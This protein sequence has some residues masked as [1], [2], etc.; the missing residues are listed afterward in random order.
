M[1]RLTITNLDLTLDLNSEETILRQLVRARLP[2]RHNCRGRARCTT[3]RLRVLEGGVNLG[4]KNRFE[5]FVLAFKE[6]AEPDI[7]LACQIIMSGDAVVEFVNNLPEDETPWKADPEY[8]LP[9]WPEEEMGHP[10]MGKE[11]PT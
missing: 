4:Q 9:V 10:N 8:Q 11:C 2:L 3:C 5:E 7:R 6:I 1:P